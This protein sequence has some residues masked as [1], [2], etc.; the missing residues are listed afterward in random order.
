MSNNPPNII[1]NPQF[2]DYKK[3]FVQRLPRYAIKQIN[4]KR[5]STKI[6]YYVINLFGHILRESSMLEH[7]DAGILSS[8]Y[9]TLT[10]FLLS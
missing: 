2:N 3:T 4:G 8:P 1:D 5:W 10:M 7:W 9:S 6:Y